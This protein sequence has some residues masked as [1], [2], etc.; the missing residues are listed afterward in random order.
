MPFKTFYN[1]LFDGDL[2][3]QF[4]KPKVNNDGKVI[5]PDILK[6][7]SPITH[8][9][10]ISVFMSNGK[11]NNFLNTYFN[12]IGLLYLDKAEFFKFMK[13]CVIDFKIKRKDILFIPFKKQDKLF[14]LLRDKIAVV[15]DH[16]ITL[17]CDI[18]NTSKD[19]REIYKSLGLEDVK[20]EK[21]KQRKKTDKKITLED[22]LS[23]NFSVVEIK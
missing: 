12:N 15:K 1:W 3:S 11:L 18:I 19:K 21:V 20:K 2:K 9:Y 8:K 6:Y 16:D 14:N 23:E 22:F 17:L 5:V 4:P 7:N 13:R 10:V